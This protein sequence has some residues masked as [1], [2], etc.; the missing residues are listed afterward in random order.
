MKIP[1]TIVTDVQ[2][3]FN[4]T[5]VKHSPDVWHNMISTPLSSEFWGKI[6]INGLEIPGTITMPKPF[7]YLSVD[8]AYLKCQKCIGKNTRRHHR[9]CSKRGLGHKGREA[10][11]RRLETQAIEKCGIV[12]HVRRGRHGNGESLDRAERRVITSM[13]PRHADPVKMALSH[14]GSDIKIE[15]PSP[16]TIS[17]TTDKTRDD[18]KPTTEKTWNAEQ[19]RFDMPIGFCVMVNGERV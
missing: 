15:Y 10:N 17:V 14:F 9:K 4:E 5:L 8:Y 18:S 7:P 12:L 19:F 1:E 2:N 6:M 11:V 16:G 3:F 13:G